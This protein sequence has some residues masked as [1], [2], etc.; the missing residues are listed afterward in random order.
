[1]RLGLLAPAYLESDPL[2]EAYSVQERITGHPE[3][4]LFGV[5]LTGNDLIGQVATPNLG[6]VLLQALST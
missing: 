3:V 1:M 2:F 6:R 5:N 4:G